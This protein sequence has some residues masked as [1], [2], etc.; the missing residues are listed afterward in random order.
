MFVD[1]VDPESQ[2]PSSNTFNNRP[3]QNFETSAQDYTLGEGGGKENKNK[4]PS[5]HVHLH[6]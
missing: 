4:T 1:D 3:T 5:T 2:N 6:S